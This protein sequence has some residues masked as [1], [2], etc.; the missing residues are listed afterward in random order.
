MDIRIGEITADVHATD[1]RPVDDDPTIERIARRVMA[2]IDQRSRAE[3]RGR[4]DRAIESS[5]RKD[6]ETYG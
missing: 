6:L 3:R 4:S 1:D 5:D 2:L